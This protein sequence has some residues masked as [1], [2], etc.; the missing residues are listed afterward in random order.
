M[1]RSSR[2][3]TPSILKGLLLAQKSLLIHISSIETRNSRPLR[4]KLFCLPFLR[5]FASNNHFWIRFLQSIYTVLTH[6]SSLACGSALLYSLINPSKDLLSW[7]LLLILSRPTSAFQSFSTPHILLS[8]LVTSALDNPS[9]ILASQCLH[10]SFPMIFFTSLLLPHNLS[11]TIPNT[12]T[13]HFT[14][15]CFIELCRCCS[16]Y[17]LKARPSTSKKMTTYCDVCFIAILAFLQWSGTDSTVA[18]RYACTVLQVFWKLP[19]G[20]PIYFLLIS[21]EPFVYLPFLSH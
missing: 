20:R 2:P 16:F 4:W 10:S 17:K 8:S 21:Q 19:V 12:N 11:S 18:P 14:E 1:R 6:L 13:P 3:L 5:S 7:L 9:K 15:L